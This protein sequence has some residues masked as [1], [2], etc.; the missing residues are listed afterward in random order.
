MVEGALRK[1]DPLEAAHVLSALCHTRC[2]RN[3]LFQLEPIATQDDIEADASLAVDIFLRAYR[4]DR[5]IER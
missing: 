5:T 3:A 4:Q 2:F 1:A